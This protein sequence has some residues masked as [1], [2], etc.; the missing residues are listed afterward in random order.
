MIILIMS[1]F[2]CNAF[3]FL[4]KPGPPINLAATETTKTSTIL[5]WQPPESDGGRPVKGYI[6]ERLSPHSKRW[7]KVVKQL[8]EELTLSVTDLEEGGQYQFRVSAENEAGVGEP[9]EPIT[10]IAKDPFG[11]YGR[12]Q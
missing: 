10:L 11:E 8:V 12:R 6:V 2:S 1:E 3:L 9:C 5:T 4:D 7:T